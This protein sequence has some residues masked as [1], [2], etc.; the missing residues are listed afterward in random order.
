MHGIDFNKFY[1]E[2]FMTGWKQ[3]FFIS[4]IE[5]YQRLIKKGVEE[6][7][8]QFCDIKKLLPATAD[9]LLKAAEN[10]DFS[11]RDATQNFL[12]QYNDLIFKDTETPFYKKVEKAAEEY[13]KSER[14]KSIYKEVTAFL[15]AAKSLDN[16]AKEGEV[17]IIVYGA[18]TKNEHQTDPLGIYRID[19]TQKR[20][21]TAKDCI[22]IEEHSAEEI[23]T[24]LEEPG[25]KRL[26]KGNRVAV[27]SYETEFGYYQI[28]YMNPKKPWMIMRA[29]YETPVYVNLTDEYGCVQIDSISRLIRF[30]I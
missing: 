23:K 19:D 29:P 28:K 5:M 16:S 11:D 10:V 22:T 17:P 6:K 4:Q 2:D 27:G 25:T 13:V 9:I 20:I 3:G 1:A 7:Y 26:R 8:L 14:E 15:K 21:D 30:D 18:D 12:L 24:L